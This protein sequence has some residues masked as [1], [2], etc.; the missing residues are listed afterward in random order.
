MNVCQDCGQENRVRDLTTFEGV[1]RCPD[2][3]GAMLER[4]DPDLFP[5]AATDEPQGC[6]R[7]IGGKDPVYLEWSENNRDLTV[8]VTDNRRGVTYVLRVPTPES[9]DPARLESE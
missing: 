4:E 2:C 5:D 8:R 1:S 3:H 9:G 7:V 6:V